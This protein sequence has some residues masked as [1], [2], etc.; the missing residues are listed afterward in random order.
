MT[1][2]P[3]PN[4][5]ASPTQAYDASQPLIV[6]DGVCMF[7]SGFVRLI[8]RLDRE[9][10]FRFATAQSPLGEALFREHGLPTDDYDSNLAI[11][12][13]AAFTKLDSFVAVMAALGWPWRA[14][15]ALLILPR[16]LRDWLY[17]RV[18]RNRYAL[19]CR[20]Q[21]CEIPSAKLRERLVG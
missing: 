21:S 9:K 3:E 2:L 13:G 17:D 10:R 19:F 12:D 4:R 16:P 20:K 8:L 1:D 11:I 14:T 7:C 5:P 6:F 18:A 15:K